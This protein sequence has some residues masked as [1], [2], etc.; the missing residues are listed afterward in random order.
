MYG[1]GVVERHWIW[2]ILIHDEHGRIH[3]MAARGAQDAM[4][5][6]SASAARSLSGLLR[7]LMDAPRSD[8]L[9]VLLSVS[10]TVRDGDLLVRWSL[11]SI[12]QRS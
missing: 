11:D 12:L 2:A 3:R 5:Q 8:C 10:M 1:K 4:Y 9:G 7:S 6:V